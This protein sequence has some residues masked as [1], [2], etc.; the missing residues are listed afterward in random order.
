MTMETPIRQPVSSNG[1]PLALFGFEKLVVGHDCAPRRYALNRPETKTSKLKASWTPAF[2]FDRVDEACLLQNA[3]N[4]GCAQFLVEAVWQ[5]PNETSDA[6][7]MVRL[8]LPDDCRVPRVLVQFVRL[9][10]NVRGHSSLLQKQRT[11][12]NGKRLRGGER[13]SIAK[14][15]A[16]ANGMGQSHWNMNVPSWRI[17]NSKRR[18]QR[19]AKLCGGQK[20]GGSL[21]CRS[22]G[23]AARS[24]KRARMEKHTEQG[25]RN[26]E[27][28][29]VLA[30]GTT[31]RSMK[32]NTHG[33]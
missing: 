3:S 23:T 1:E 4:G 2:D 6:G 15:Q 14:E 21:S 19:M 26:P 32:S 17:S 30:S 16:L 27:R 8:P 31:C 20:Q 13:N 24:E 11:R 12:R 10:R 9:S 29:R 25:M 22:M 18:Q 33:S 5:L 7:A 28:A